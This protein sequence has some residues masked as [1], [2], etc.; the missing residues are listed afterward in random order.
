M[1]VYISSPGGTSGG[2]E[3]QSRTFAVKMRLIDMNLDKLQLIPEDEKLEFV[4]EA[5][6]QEFLKCVAEMNIIHT[7]LFD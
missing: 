7:E 2:P 5:L 3:Q 6:K 4:A 1:P